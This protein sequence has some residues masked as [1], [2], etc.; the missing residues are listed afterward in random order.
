MS[1]I[2]FVKENKT[3]LQRKIDF[4]FICWRKSFHH[5]SNF[6]EDLQEEA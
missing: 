1:Y 2:Y 4:N 5:K 6:K 3:F